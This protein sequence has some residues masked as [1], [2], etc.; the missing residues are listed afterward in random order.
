MHL[1]KKENAKNNIHAADLVG[2]LAQQLAKEAWIL[3]FDEF[4]VVDIA[5]AMILKRLFFELWKNGTIC[6]ITGNRKPEDLYKN[7]LQYKN[8]QPFIP[9]LLQHVDEN[10][11][12]SGVDYRRKEIASHGESF[13]L[14]TLPDSNKKFTQKLLETAK[15]S[16][17]DKLKPKELFVFGR[18][19]SIERTHGR[20]ALFNFS[21][22]CEAPLAAQDYL[23]IASTFDVIFIRD[24][25]RMDLQTQRAEARR[26]ISLI[27]QLYDHQTG[28][29]YLAE[30]T[31]ENIF[32]V[33]DEVRTEFSQEERQFMDDL[34]IQ[35]TKAAEALSIIS[36]EEEAFALKRMISRLYDMKTQDYWDNVSRRIRDSDNTK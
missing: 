26:W 35:G 6:I 29:V 27:D 19:L 3:C 34:Q 24:I 28:V 7:G 16:S 8:F 32:Y 36:G 15:I 14:S 33:K 11:M 18:K 20:I 9:L 13:Y 30:E 31:P 4:Q 12:N 5:D 10:H 1:L 25:K 2:P 22:L 17:L 23:E 21:E